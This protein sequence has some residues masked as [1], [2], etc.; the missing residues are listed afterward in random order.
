MSMSDA[1]T[2]IETTLFSVTT[3]V[4]AIRVYVDVAS[5]TQN[6]KLRTSTLL[7]TIGYLFYTVTYALEVSNL[8][9]STPLP[10]VISVQK[11]LVPAALLAIK[12]SL[13][14]MYTLL[15]LKRQKMLMGS[16]FGFL[17]GIFLAVVIIER[18]GCRPWLSADCNQTRAVV[19][20]TALD[21]SGYIFVAIIPVICWKEIIKSEKFSVLAMLLLTT[22]V[23]ALSLAHAVLRLD[24]ATYPK[25][26]LPDV[27]VNAELAAALI[28][29]SLPELWYSL[30]GHLRG[31]GIG[32]RRNASHLSAVQDIDGNKPDGGRGG[33][34]GGG[35]NGSD[36]EAPNHFDPRSLGVLPDSIHSSLRSEISTPRQ[37]PIEDWQAESREALRNMRR[38]SREISQPCVELW[39]WD[40]DTASNTI[41]ITRTPPTAAITGVEGEGRGG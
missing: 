4:H 37:P 2:A 15:N 20:T 25:S 22:A 24:R 21:V 10:D 3:L 38:D 41:T 28:I 36:P 16:A 23:S 35:S 27:L 13:V 33:V 31:S 6:R 26:L 39:P 17:A 12:S 18:I 1:G 5:P 7:A 30:Q 9:S 40:L 11:V 29:A 32:N 14:A 34:V 19:A 8:R